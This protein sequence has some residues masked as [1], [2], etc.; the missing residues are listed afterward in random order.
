[1]Q[2]SKTAAVFKGTG[3]KLH[4]TAF[5]SFKALFP[6]GSS[7]FGCSSTFS[8]FCHRNKDQFHVDGYDKNMSYNPQVFIPTLS[9]SVDDSK[10]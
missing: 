8:T 6:V 7:G 3:R 9:S 2:Y 4:P 5:S 1:M 10:A